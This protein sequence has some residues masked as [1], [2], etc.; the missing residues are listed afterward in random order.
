[1]DQKGQ[2]IQ[3]H[4]QGTAALQNR[5]FE[6]A[7]MAAP[8]LPPPYVKKAKPPTFD[9]NQMQLM[10]PRSILPGQGGNILF[11]KRPQSAKNMNTV[12][13]RPMS[14]GGFAGGQDTTN[15]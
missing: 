1:M 7:N 12:I 13:S 4:Y 8:R 5:N 11:E 3:P 2:D 9:K 14:C 6:N 10:Q 15:L